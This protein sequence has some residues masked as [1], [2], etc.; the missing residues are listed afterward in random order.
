M[1][2]VP[3]VQS[4]SSRESSS[5]PERYLFQ[6]SASQKEPIVVN[7]VSAMSTHTGRVGLDGYRF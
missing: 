2:A 3:R 4:E 6:A 7:S 5:S 1:K